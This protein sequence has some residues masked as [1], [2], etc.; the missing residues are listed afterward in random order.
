MTTVVLMALM[1]L[2]TVTRLGE[3]ESAGPFLEAAVRILLGVP[4]VVLLFLPESTA[5]F[6]RER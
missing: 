5:W 6:D 3:A 1:V 2:P 4:V